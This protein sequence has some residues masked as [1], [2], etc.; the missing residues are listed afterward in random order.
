VCG[1]CTAAFAAHARALCV[2]ESGAGNQGCSG[3][4]HHHAIVHWVVLHNL[5]CPRYN[6]TGDL[7][8]RRERQSS[9]ELLSISRHYGV[10]L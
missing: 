7:G 2:R 6:D 10:A 4:A 3:D 9:A 1:W 5:H 8:F